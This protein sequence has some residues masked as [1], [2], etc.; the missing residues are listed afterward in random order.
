[1]RFITEYKFDILFLVK[2]W[3]VNTIIFI[4]NNMNRK[5]DFDCITSHQNI[6]KEFFND[7]HLYITGSLCPPH[8][9]ACSYEDA[10]PSIYL[11]VCLSVPYWLLPKGTLDLHSAPLSIRLS[12]QKKNFHTFFPECWLILSW[13]FGVW[14]NIGE[15]QVVF[16]VSDINRQ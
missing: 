2:L 6:L 16:W 3:N 12:V 15:L 4:W 13:F 1:M 11:F 7:I 10:C 14:V 9:V 8:K 5:K